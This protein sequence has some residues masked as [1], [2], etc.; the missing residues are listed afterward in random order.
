MTQLHKHFRMTFKH[1]EI[2]TLQCMPCLSQFYTHA[3]T[4]HCQFCIIN[5]DTLKAGSDSYELSVFL[6]WQNATKSITRQDE[7]T[8]VYS[9]MPLLF[10]FFC[11]YKWSWVSAIKALKAQQPSFKWRKSVT[12]QPLAK[13]AAFIC[14]THITV[15]RQ[16]SRLN[17]TMTVIEWTAQIGAIFQSRIYTAFRIVI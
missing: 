2:R 4:P 15:S 5:D 6:R 13:H 12:T 3:H 10:F 8:S 16:D 7:I 11:F 14:G 17:L 1:L 9:L